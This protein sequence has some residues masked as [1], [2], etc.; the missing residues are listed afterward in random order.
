MRRGIE[1]GGDRDCDSDHYCSSR[2]DTGTAVYIRACGDDRARRNDRACGDDRA[3]R[4]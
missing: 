2:I 4:D 3:C 1:P